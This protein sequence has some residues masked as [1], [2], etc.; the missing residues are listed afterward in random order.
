MA[1]LSAKGVSHEAIAERLGL[2]HHSVATIL[3]RRRPAAPQQRQ[4]AVTVEHILMATSIEF[5]VKIEAMLSA[6]RGG[7]LVLARQ[8]AADVA[9]RLTDLMPEQIAK[10]LSRDRTNILRAQRAVAATSRKYPELV[11]RIQRIERLARG[12]ALSGAR[13]HASG[14]PAAGHDQGGAAGHD[15]G[16][17]AGHEGGVSA[18][19]AAGHGVSENA[20]R[21]GSSDDYATRM[22]CRKATH[23]LGRLLL[24]EIQHAR[25][26]SPLA[27][28]DSAARS[29]PPGAIEG[30]AVA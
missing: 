28:G 17:N 7:T 27:P 26:E 29:R 21:V 22:H 15:E 19:P 30:G 5:G 25:A 23:E 20:D 12:Y 6:L 3:A 2:E 16:G 9:F 18:K 4:T 10:A 1:E 8:V 11:F 13:R 14:E 24:A